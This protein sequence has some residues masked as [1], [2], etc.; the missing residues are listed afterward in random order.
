V[1]TKKSTLSCSSAVYIVW[2]V[3]FASKLDLICRICVFTLELCNNFS[4]RTPVAHWRKRVPRIEFTRY[5]TEIIMLG[6]LHF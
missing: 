2:S 3:I 1:R 5:P 4:R 6:L